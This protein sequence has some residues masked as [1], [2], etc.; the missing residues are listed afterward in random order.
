MDFYKIYKPIT[1]TPFARDKSY[2]EIEPCEALKPY[3]RCFW[4]SESPYMDEPEEEPDKLVVP[5]TCM[6]IIFRT[7]F[8]DNTQE[9]SFCGM[10]DA[11]FVSGRH[12]FEKCAEKSIFGIRFYAWSA[13]LFSE[14]S[15]KN[16][17]NKFYDAGQ[18]FSQIK[19]ELEQ[20]FFEVVSLKDRVRI[21]EE[22]L[23]RML[24][25]RFYNPLVVEAVGEILKR[26]G[27]LKALELS[28]EMHVSERQLERVFKEYIGISPKQ[29]S[30][31]VRYQYLWKDICVNPNFRILDE[32][33]RYGYTDQA[34]LLHDFKRFHTMS[35]SEAKEY[36][37]SDVGFLQEG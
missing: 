7:N 29:L 19:K 23:L 10:N 4:G 18:H 8:T 3:I 15:L 24:G 5:D 28:R 2:V 36:A 26:K 33:Y 13:V 17:K 35:L 12:S 11:A 37:F 14:E 34:H 16:T 22:V 27:N 1:A 20:R 9:S 30:S 25:N 32:V 6:D 31:L 21:A